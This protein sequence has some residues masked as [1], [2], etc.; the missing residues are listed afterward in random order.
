MN[1]ELN[2]AR[3][4]K[5][6]VY[7][8]EENDFV[9][10]YDKR[11]ESLKP[12]IDDE[13]DY[14]YNEYLNKKHYPVTYLKF[15]DS[16]SRTDYNL[17][18][19]D[20]FTHTLHYSKYHYPMPQNPFSLKMETYLDPYKTYSEAEAKELA[21]KIYNELMSLKPI[22]FDQ[23]TDHSIKYREFITLTK[24]PR[25]RENLA[26]HI[27]KELEPHYGTIFIDEP[28]YPSVEPLDETKCTISITPDLQIKVSVT[29]E[30]RLHQF[31]K[32]VNEYVETVDGLTYNHRTREFVYRSN[33][34]PNL[35]YSYDVDDKQPLNT[36]KQDIERNIR[37]HHLLKDFDYR[38]HDYIGIGPEQPN[39][40]TKI[41]FSNERI[42]GRFELHNDRVQVKI[43]QYQ[44]WDS[45][46]FSV[47]LDNTTKIKASTTMDDIDIKI[48]DTREL[49]AD[50]HFTDNVQAMI[51][52][53]KSYVVK[54]HDE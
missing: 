3:V 17:D 48:E 34:G 36:V 44:C 27:H 45:S 47:Q 14:L 4:L 54:D 12:Q 1:K 30:E 8:L 35:Y 49:K 41:N 5:Q 29:S 26:E 9:L 23:N 20:S 33:E 7:I 37:L 13:H 31:N 43:V 6:L 18:Y 46:G 25:T 15:R 19:R 28:F 22:L 11:F 53:V 2:V 52:N 51:E 10:Y 32:N 40:Y 38:F 24:E 50:E 21:E 42:Y 16:E 39:A